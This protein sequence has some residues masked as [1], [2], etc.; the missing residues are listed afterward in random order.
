[1]ETKMFYTLIKRD[2]VIGK[3]KIPI[4]EYARGVIYGLMTAY[5][6]ENKRYSIMPSNDGFV[7]RMVG[8]EKQY[9]Y[10]KNTVENIYPDVCVFN[11]EI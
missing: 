1:M 4:N 7:L 8:N 9:A 3:N 11:Y 6:E 10:F 2:A 5:S